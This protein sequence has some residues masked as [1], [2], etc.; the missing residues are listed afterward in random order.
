[1]TLIIRVSSVVVNL[2]ALVVKLIKTC[3]TRLGSI[4]RAE[5]FGQHEFHS[6]VS[7]LNLAFEHFQGALNN[8]ERLRIHWRDLFHMSATYAAINSTNVPSTLHCQV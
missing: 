5:R 1:M 4:Q 3:S 8:L 7:C 2:M 6:N